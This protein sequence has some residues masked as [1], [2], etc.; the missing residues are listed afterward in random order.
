MSRDYLLFLEEIRPILDQI[1]K[2]LVDEAF[3][4]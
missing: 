4:D 3:K 1:D 2:I